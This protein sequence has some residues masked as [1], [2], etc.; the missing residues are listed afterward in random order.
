VVFVQ[1]DWRGNITG[2]YSGRQ[3]YAQEELP[4]DHPEVVEFN[5]KHPVP[6]ELLCGPTTE[7]IA[8]SSRQKEKL[9]AEESDMRRQTDLFRNSFNEL[10]IALSALLYA[11]LNAKGRVAYAVYYSV[12]SFEARSDLVGNAL[13]QVASENEKLAA[14]LDKRCWPFLV[15]RIRRVRNVR[16]AIAHGTAQRIYIGR[17]GYV[18]HMP[19]AFDAIRIGRIVAKRQIPGLSAH[20]IGEA[21]QPMRQICDC[22]DRIN[23]IVAASHDP[24][25]PT[26][27]ERFLRLAEHL[28][29]LRG[30]YPSVPIQE[31]QRGLDQ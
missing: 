26:L 9:K 31:T 29:N 1:R 7:E 20:D 3:D 22:I 13:I 5:A 28:R 16:N 4:D 25:D 11:I 12:N 24:L 18:R 19:P 14:L 27:P 8:E 15:T 30:N 2:L 10:E 17:K 21:W 6:A 23:E